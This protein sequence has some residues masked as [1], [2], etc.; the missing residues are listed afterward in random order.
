M[1]LYTQYAIVFFGDSIDDL[2]TVTVSVTV[3]FI[4]L[5]FPFVILKLS[6]L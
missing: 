3:L 1:Y 6:S 2:K 5:Y 4:D